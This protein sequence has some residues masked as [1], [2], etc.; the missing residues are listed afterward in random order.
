MKKKFVSQ[1]PAAFCEYRLVLHAAPHMQERVLEIKNELYQFCKLPSVKF[2]AAQIRLVD[3]VHD[4]KGE[5]QLVKN[6]E[7]MAMSYSP[8]KITLNDFGSLPSHSIFINVESKQQV[9]NLLKHL[10]PAQSWMTFKKENQPHFLNDPFILI[11][12]KL[13]P[14][15]YEKCWLHYQ[16]QH[17]SGNFLA[18]NFLLMKRS[19]HDANYH[20]V[21]RFQFLNLPTVKAQ[22]ELF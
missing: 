5:N 3:F 11:A 21:E 17:F 12:S 2:S 20:L 6:L 4:Q 7:K 19:Q 1:I 8:F 18:E 15:Q 22:G 9:Y 13:L 16:Y 10:K 14:W